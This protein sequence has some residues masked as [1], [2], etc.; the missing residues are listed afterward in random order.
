MLVNSQEFDNFTLAASPSRH[1]EI[2]MGLFKFFPRYLV[3]VA[4]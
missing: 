3:V 2:F 4:M 1:L